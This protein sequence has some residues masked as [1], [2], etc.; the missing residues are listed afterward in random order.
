MKIATNVSQKIF[1]F[2]EFLFKFLSLSP[3]MLET[4]PFF[5]GLSRLVKPMEITIILDSNW[6]AFFGKGF[7]QRKRLLNF[8]QVELIVAIK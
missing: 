1:S 8:M 6:A 4:F 2:Q 7:L 5:G 3:V